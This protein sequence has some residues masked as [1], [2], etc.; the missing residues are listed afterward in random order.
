MTK[1]KIED[2]PENVQHILKIMRGEIELPPRKRIKPIDF[3][4]Y[5]AKD[6]FPNSPDMQRYFNKMKHKELERRKYVGEIKNRY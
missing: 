1:M 2:L 6:V 3:Y 4:S 5:E